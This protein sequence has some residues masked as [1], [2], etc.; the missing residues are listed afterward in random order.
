[1]GG[2]LLLR[3]HGVD[4]EHDGQRGQRVLA[5]GDLHLVAVAPAQPGLADADDLP[6]LLEDAVVVPHRSPST[7]QGMPAMV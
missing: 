4:G 3:Q 7:V 1:M 5:A 6:P 2:G